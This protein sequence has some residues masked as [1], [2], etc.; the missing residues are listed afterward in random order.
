MAEKDHDDVFDSTI[1]GKKSFSDLLKDIYSNSKSKEKQI[2]I[3]IEELRPLVKTIGDATVIVPLI[4]EY[5]DVGVKNDEILVKMAAIVQRS[6]QTKSSGASGVG[7]LGITQDEIDQLE[8]T[9]SANSNNAKKAELK[10]DATLNQ[11][12]KEITKLVDE[13]KIISNNQGASNV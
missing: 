11:K 8:A 4:K 2:T 1:F 13:S 10:I 5:M 3:L 9:V 7:D 12:I 6:I